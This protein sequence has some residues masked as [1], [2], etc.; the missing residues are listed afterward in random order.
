MVELLEQAIAQNT[1]T[2]AVDG[3]EN[4]PYEP[5]TIHS[6]EGHTRAVMK[7]Q[8]GCDNH[9]TY[10]IIPSVRGSVRSRPLNAIREEARALAEAGFRELVLTGI[11]LTS[12]GRELEDRPTLAQAVEAA[13]GTR[14]VMRVRLGSLEPRVATDTF[15]TA[16]RALPQMCPQFHLALQSGSDSVLRRMK[17][18]YNTR[19]FWEAVWPHPCGMAQRRLHH[20]RYC[21]LPRRNRGGIFPDA[22][23]LRKGRLCAPACVPL[24]PA[25]GNAA[26]V[27]EEQIPE[28]V[29]AERVR[30]LIA[31]GDELA[32]RYHERF[33]GAEADVLLEERQPDGSVMGYTPEYIHVRVSSGEPG[34]LVRVR[35]DGLTQEGMHGT[36]VE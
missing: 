3:V 19:Q 28:A 22:C 16:L 1:Q 8:E 15:V 29:K 21:W 2:V 35:L 31:L 17:R 20:G 9:C 26:A 5:L 13:C 23:L 36:V 24:Q 4:V 11:H 10:C 33:L 25:R 30:R 6:H 18:G 32:K 7:I 27:M 34:S 12:Y 14:G